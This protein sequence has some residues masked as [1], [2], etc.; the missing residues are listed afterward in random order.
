VTPTPSVLRAIRNHENVKLDVIYDCNSEHREGLENVHQDFLRFKI[1]DEVK[2]MLPKVPL[3][4]DDDTFMPFR[5]PTCWS[6]IRIAISRKGNI[7]SDAVWFALK[8]LPKVVD[9]TWYENDLRF[10]IRGLQIEKTALLF[11][12][13]RIVGC[14]ALGAE[15][16]NI[17]H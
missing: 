6:G 7:H 9:D 15:V 4:R 8:D 5:P 13:A 12:E 17:E 1:A 11:L 3:P 10:A 14:D 2:A 16:L